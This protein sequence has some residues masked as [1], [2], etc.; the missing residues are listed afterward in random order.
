MAQ[1][2]LGGTNT[3]NFA[4]GE[5]PPAHSWEYAGVGAPMKKAAPTTMPRK[6]PVIVATMRETILI[7]KKPKKW[8]YLGIGAAVGAVATYLGLKIRSF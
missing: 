4:R 1:D 6:T 3:K 5:P 2:L 8:K 7:E